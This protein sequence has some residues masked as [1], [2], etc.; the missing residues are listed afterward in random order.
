MEGTVSRAVAAGDGLLHQLAGLIVSVGQSL[1]WLSYDCSSTNSRLVSPRS[2]LST[3]SADSHTLIACRLPHPP[4]STIPTPPLPPLIAAAIRVSRLSHPHNPSLF[5]HRHHQ[6]DALLTS[7]H[8]LCT[9]PHHH[10]LPSDL[11]SPRRHVTLGAF[12]LTLLL[13]RWL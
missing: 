7:H 9:R 4:H 11:L 13:L 5:A 10:K 12:S 1:G 2:P 6:H 8:T 3:L